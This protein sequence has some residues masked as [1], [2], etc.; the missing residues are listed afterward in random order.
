MFAV[1]F[2]SAHR[3]FYKAGLLLTHGFHISAVSCIAG[4]RFGFAC[5]DGVMAWQRSRKQPSPAPAFKAGCSLLDR[6]Y[7]LMGCGMWLMGPWIR[8]FNPDLNQSGCS[9]IQVLGLAA[10]L[11]SRAHNAARW[12]VLLCAAFQRIW[13][14]QNMRLGVLRVLSARFQ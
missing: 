3:K 13:F 10:L 6:F 4:C 12:R 1:S 14:A 5:S 8:A 7:L 9:N 2:G 11:S